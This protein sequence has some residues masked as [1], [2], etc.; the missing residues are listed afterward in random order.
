MGYDDLKVN[1]YRLADSAES[2]GFLKNEFD[3]IEDRRDGTRDIW[4]HDGVREAMDEF[5]SNMDYN[6]G[7]LSTKLDEMRKKVDGTLDAFVEA[8]GELAKSFDDDRP[9]R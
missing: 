4:G 2:L 8:D 5:A 9:A 6:R 3:D 1:Y 7:K